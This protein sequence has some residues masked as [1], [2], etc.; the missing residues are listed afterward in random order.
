MQPQMAGGITEQLKF[1][2]FPSLTYKL[3]DVITRSVDDIKAFAQSLAVMLAI[4]RFDYPIYDDSYG[5]EL[6]QYTGKSFSYL[7]TTIE[8]TLRDSIL[9]DD[10]I[11]DV[12]VI[13][14]EKSGTDTAYTTVDV[15]TNTGNIERMEF[16]VHL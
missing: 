15:Y 2:S 1:V 9:Q 8:N 13:S 6:R 16:N 7:E 3:E 4:E 10:R 12:M 14:V 11:L 5:M